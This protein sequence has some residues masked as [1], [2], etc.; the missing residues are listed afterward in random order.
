MTQRLTYAKARNFTG[1]TLGGATCPVPDDQI[2]VLML[3]CLQRMH[4]DLSD[5]KHYQTTVELELVDGQCEYDLPALGIRK[6]H[7]VEDED[8]E[9]LEYC[10]SPPNRRQKGIKKVTK[11][12]QQSTKF[13]YKRLSGKYPVG[14]KPY[15]DA[16]CE[17]G[18]CDCPDV[19]TPSNWSCY[20]NKLI[21]WPVP[22][23]PEGT[24]CTITFRGERALDCTLYTVEDGVKE[25]KYVD[26]PV[27]YHSVYAKCLMGMALASCDDI[28]R[29]N[30]WLSVARDEI[31]AIKCMD[32]MPLFESDAKGDNVFCVGENACDYARPC[33]P[34]CDTKLLWEF[35]EVDGEIETCSVC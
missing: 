4:A 5:D 34:K 28:E 8:C 26:L 35:E 7:S 14:G 19:V 30:W 33:K 6:F 3:N 17:D 25:W 24:T 22:Q 27:N 9:Q 21:L 2:E 20:G 32:D 11:V 10:A 16:A 13:P 29:G 31:E 15:M 18:R 23:V 1:N 12:C